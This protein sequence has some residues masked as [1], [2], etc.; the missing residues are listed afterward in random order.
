[1]LICDRPYA[2]CTFMQLDCHFFLCAFV[3]AGRVVPCEGAQ[4]NALGSGRVG[5]CEGGRIKNVKL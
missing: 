5:S 1:M 2:V 4:G 3:R